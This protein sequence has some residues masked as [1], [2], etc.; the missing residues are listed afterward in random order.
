[1]ARL[2][3]YGFGIVFG[4]GTDATIVSHYVPSVTLG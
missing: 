1:M 4:L 2:L 3:R